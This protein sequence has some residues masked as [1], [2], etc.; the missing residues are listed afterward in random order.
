MSLDQIF[1]LEIG[2]CIK[3]LKSYPDNYFHSI[4]TDPPYNIKIN[5]LGKKSDWDDFKSN[6]QFGKWCEQW[7]KEC[8]RVLKPG[9]HIIA[10]SSQ[11]TCHRLTCAIEDSGFKIKDVINWIYFSG[12]PKGLRSK[13]KMRNTV[14]KPCTEPAVLAMKPIE[15]RTYNDQYDKTQTGY[16]FI[17]ECR[18]PAGSEHWIGQND[19]DFTKAWTDRVVYSNFTSGGRYNVAD[20]GANYHARD[21]SEYAPTGRFPANIFHCKKVVS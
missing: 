18:F 1:K 3:V 5:A 8:F 19:G 11:R 7:A 10:F 16:L 12:M 17:E 13:D 15:E 14:L 6:K 4:V 21:L 2:D 20:K 9:G